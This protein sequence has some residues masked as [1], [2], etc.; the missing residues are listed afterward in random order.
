MTKR[1][2]NE[3]LV[4]C[5][6][7]YAALK[8]FLTEKGDLSTFRRLKFMTKHMGAKPAFHSFYN[9]LDTDESREIAK[10]VYLPAMQYMEYKENILKTLP[11][12]EN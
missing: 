12:S 5:R 9:I 3:Q 2:N 10:E 8:D 1:M 6:A 11:F 7:A 4:K